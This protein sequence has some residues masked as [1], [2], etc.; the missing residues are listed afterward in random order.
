[1]FSVLKASDEKEKEELTTKWVEAV[2]KEI[3]PLLKDAGPFFGGS[4]RLTLAEVSRVLFLFRSGVCW[5]EVQLAGAKKMWCS[6]MC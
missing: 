5:A 4:R 3:E 2:K 1:M 6:D